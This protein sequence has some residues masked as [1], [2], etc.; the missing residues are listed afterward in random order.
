M[1]LLNADCVLEPGFLAAGRPHLETP[2][3]GSVAP[4]LIR[5]AAAG[6][7]DTA[8]MVVDRRRKNGLVGHGLP[9]TSFARAAPA[10][11]G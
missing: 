2:D 8:A 10:F 7:I 5:A 4:K 1:L 11:G 3:V 6:E 9:R